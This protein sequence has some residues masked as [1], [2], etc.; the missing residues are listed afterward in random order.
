MVL[1]ISDTFLGFS[2][3]DYY[4]DR[5]MEGLEHSNI[6]HFPF[7]TPALTLQPGDFLPIVQELFHLI[8]EILPQNC[9]DIKM[10]AALP[11]NLHHFLGRLC[12]TY[13][14]KTLCN[15]KKA[16][17]SIFF[18]GNLS[19]PQILQMGTCPDGNLGDGNLS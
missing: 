5:I 19:Y 2:R 4:I 8:F 13:P 15:T 14:Q 7:T 3:H 16:F 10:L 1:F 11:G 17:N 6:T 12:E 9:L 18:D